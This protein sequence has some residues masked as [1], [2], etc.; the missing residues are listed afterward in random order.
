[1]ITK[2]L[3]LNFN[4]R[5]KLCNDANKEVKHDDIILVNYKVSP[6]RPG[7]FEGSCRLL[8]VKLSFRSRSKSGEV[9]FRSSSEVKS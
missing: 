8:F 7:K 1:M 6:H 3:L 9:Q 5:R 4:E 2:P